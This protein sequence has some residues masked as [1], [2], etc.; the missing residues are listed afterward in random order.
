M[1]PDTSKPELEEEIIDLMETVDTP[2]DCIL[3]RPNKK[4]RNWLFFT[5]ILSILLHLAVCII[6]LNATATYPVIAASSPQEA[7]WF[8]PALLF[9]SQKPA[10]NE[11]AAKNDENNG[12]PEQQPVSAKTD[13]ITATTVQDN[14]TN[15]AAPESPSNGTE[16][17]TEPPIQIARGA[18]I[19]IYTPTPEPQPAAVQAVKKP[20][21]AVPTP[22]PPP[23]KTTPKPVNRPEPKPVEMAKGIIEPQLPRREEPKITV[24]VKESRRQIIAEE[25]KPTNAISIRPVF[26][27]QSSKVATNETKPPEPALLVKVKTTSFNTP[28]MAKTVP[29]E[30]KNELPPK[31]SPISNGMAKPITIQATSA[32]RIIVKQ[33]EKRAEHQPPQQQ[34]AAVKPAVVI[35]PAKPLKTVSI[36][37]NMVTTPKPPQPVLETPAKFTMYGLPQKTAPTTR[38]MAKTII[39]PATPAVENPVKREDQ[40]PQRQTV[41]LKRNTTSKP[42]YSVIFN[43]QTQPQKLAAVSAPKPVVQPPPKPVTTAKQAVPPAKLVENTPAK[44]VKKEPENGAREKA[45]P[46][47]APAPKGLFMPPLLGDLKIELIATRDVQ[48]GVKVFVEYRDFPKAK[49]GRIIS[50]REAMHIK[51][52]KAKVVIPKSNTIQIIVDHSSE[53]IY[54]VRVQLD[55]LESIRALVRIK[56]FEAGPKARSKSLGMRTISSNETIIKILMPE[57]IFWDDADAFSGSLDDS[58]GITKYNTETGLVWKEYN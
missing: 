18:E 32:A 28:Q 10:D 6:F 55:Q 31:I 25:K 14:L 17:I 29:S 49:R 34:R 57:G 46:T 7:L 43:P 27:N 39:M 2:L 20:E 23:A 37:R 47:E 48:R 51:P 52:S 53:G 36:K 45:K 44:Q 30:V 9:G 38:S 3:V 1:E 11:E 15:V 19:S 54:Y 4:D 58:D 12:L 41:N 35:K 24:E 8:Y 40:K 26:T 5:S 56:L 50:K 33:G 42:P 13:I 22:Q 16:V 21:A